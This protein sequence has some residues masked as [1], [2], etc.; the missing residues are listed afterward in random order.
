MQCKLKAVRRLVTN[1]PP[2]LTARGYSA[3]QAAR[4]AADEGQTR[5]GIRIEIKIV[6]R[7]CIPPNHNLNRNLNQK[8]MIIGDVN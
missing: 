1:E 8:T 5:F 7:M 2:A 3:A 6:I 4:D